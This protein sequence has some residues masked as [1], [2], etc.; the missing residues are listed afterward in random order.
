LSDTNILNETIEEVKKTLHLKF[1][2]SERIFY[3][4]KLEC[5]KKQFYLKEIRHYDIMANIP[6]QIL[7]IKD[8]T[9]KYDWIDQ[10]IKDLA[11]D[12]M[13]NYLLDIKENC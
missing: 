13:N 8:E 6:E 9:T 4:Q 1:D 11:K 2:E 12:F 3:E 10:T 5:A 7:K